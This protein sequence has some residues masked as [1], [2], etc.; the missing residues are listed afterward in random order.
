MISGHT[1]VLGVIGD[2]V[3]HTSSPAMH[4]AALQELGL[5]YVYVP[6]HVTAGQL[7]E[8]IA[9]MRGLGMRGMNVTVPHKQ[10]VM[11]HV[12]EVAPE[13]EAIGAVNTIVNDDGLLRGHN[14]D[15]YGVM[16]S[17]RRDAGLEGLPARIALL[18]AGG[19]A[20][21][22][23]YA[24]LQCVEVER[25]D[26]FNRTRERA[27]ALAADLEPA[28][29]RVAVAALGDGS[30]DGAELV[31]NS[32]SVGMTPDEDGT[33]LPGEG[34][35]HTGMTLLDIVYNPLET[36]LMRQAKGAGAHAVNGLGMLAYQGAGSF[37]LWTGQ[38][39][40]AAA[41]KS[42]ALARFG[43]GPGTPRQK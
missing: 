17:L 35:F 36:R 24:L 34:V 30:V 25:V 16:E 23:L 8:A 19:A 29:T 18:G 43:S 41:M 22:I 32:T 20:R 5:D 6:F 11:E 38:T 42:A 2:P 13:A 14:T 7:P 33:P 4:N 10:A 40:P 1:A 37:E 3:E 31:I 27:E 9:G 28:G 39:A 12:D 21:A 26:I 15:A